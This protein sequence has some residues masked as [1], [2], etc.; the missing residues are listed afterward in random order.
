MPRPTRRHL[1]VATALIAATTAAVAV[2][3]TAGAFDGKDRAKSAIQGGKARNVILLIGDGMG[4]SE[5]TLARDYTVGANGRLNMDAFPLTGAY[6]TY[7]VHADGTPDYVTD[8]AASGTGWATGV[9]TVNGRVSKTPGTDKPVRT[10]LELAQRNGYATG[11]VTTAELTDATPAVLASHVTDRSCQGPADMA[12]CP[13]D[14]IAAGGP[15]SIAEQE[16][17]H[18]VD[19]LFGGGR[20][21]FDQKVTDGRYKG[22]TVTEQARRLGYR[23]V[24]DDASMKA[25]EPGRPVLGLFAPGNVPTEWTGKPAAVGGTDPQ[26][27]VTSNP[28]RPAATPSLADSAAKAIRLLEAKQKHSRQGFFLQI[29]GASI[30]KQDHAADPCGQI[31]ETAAFDKA[32]RVA[33]A[34]AAQHPDTLVVTT[35]DHGHTSQ[36][37]PLEATPPGLSATLVTNEGQQLKVNYST[38][39]P[40]RS[41]E[42]TGTQVRIAAQG[43]LA[44]R[45]L[46]VTNQT[47]LFT[48]VREALRLR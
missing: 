30:D 9:K 11:D 45:V 48:T 13:T 35:A 24:T 6:T 2:T 23:V 28:G 37:V 14:T 46:G 26:R 41:Q 33:R 8:S 1:T 47:D 22:L 20:Q 19:V 15:G 39:T 38:N 16:V 18:K 10:L 34:Y 43:P 32:V 44:Y 29:E 12:K 27:C 25:A 17:G 36:I 7:A 40:G 31:G 21:R 4:D 3:T 42:H 5:I